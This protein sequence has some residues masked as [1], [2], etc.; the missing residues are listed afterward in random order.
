[1]CACCAPHVKSAGEIGIIKLLDTERI[2]GGI[3]IYIKCG[4]RA[5]AD[6]GERYKNEYLIGDL[7]SVK[8]NEI[9]EGVTALYSKIAELKADN[10]DLKKR[11][12]EV[13]INSA[14][15]NQRAIF[16]N[17][18]DVR[19]LQMLADGLHRRFGDIRAAFSEKESG[20]YSFAIC[21]EE[22]SLNDFFADLRKEFNVRGGGR[23]GMV[24]G[25][26]EGAGAQIKSFF[27]GI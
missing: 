12:A 22:N 11:F 23:N 24:Q 19:E 5:L 3:R 13:L 2:R 7:M 10:T 9:V 15:E 8:Q 6:Y 18:L 27:S 17:G 26:I 25:T 1:M 14:D 16:E 20:V 4:I 21:G